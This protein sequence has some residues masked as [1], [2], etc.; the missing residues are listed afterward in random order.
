MIKQISVVFDFNTDTEEVSNVKVVDSRAKATKKTTKKKDV[1]EDPNSPA[2][3]TLEANKL[4]FNQ[5][6]ANILGVEAGD[7]LI[8]KWEQEGKKMMPR[9]G[10][11]ASFDEEGAGNKVTKSN[12]ISYRGNA[13]TLL[14]QL[15]TDF[16]L[17]SEILPGV[18]QLIPLSGKEVAAPETVEKVIE[19]AD[20]VDLDLIVDSDE[21]DEIDELSFKL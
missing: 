9:I 16:T 2:E 6:A 21:T 15:G 5:K 20:E 18:Y 10:S 1:E 11:D 8:I 12:T 3:I 7:R 4:V 19:Q 17:G 13:N 14:A